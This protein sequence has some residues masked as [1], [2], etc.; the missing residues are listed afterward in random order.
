MRVQMGLILGEEATLAASL[1]VV[2]LKDVR[3]EAFRAGCLVVAKQA[4]V[5]FRVSIK[6]S[7]QSPVVGTRP[8]TE[9]AGKLLFALDFLHERLLVR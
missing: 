6:V 5:R 2:H 1:L 7:L 9:R 4:H 8:G 3:G